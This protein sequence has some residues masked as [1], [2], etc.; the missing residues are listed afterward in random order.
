M[1]ARAQVPSRDDAQAFAG[2]LDEKFL[3]LLE[4]APA[5]E[6]IVVTKRDGRIIRV[7]TQTERL[8]DYPRKELLGQNVEVL[9]QRR[10]QHRHV[11]KQAAYFSH[12]RVRLM[13]TGLEL[14]AR[15]KDGTEFPIDVSFTPLETGGETLVFGFIRDITE[16]KRSEEVVSHLAAI[17]ETSDDAIIG[18]SLDGTILSW[19]LG[20]ERLYGYKAEE[21]VGRPVALLV[22]PD[23]PDELGWIMK[24][25]RRGKHIEHYETTR[26]RKDGHR[27]DISVT[28]SPVKNKAGSV[29][30]ASVIARDI[31]DRKRIEMALRQSEER[32]RVAL[33]NAPVRV[34]NQDLDLRF[35]WI[36]SHIMAWAKQDCLGKTDAEIVDG[37]EGARLMAF[38]KEVLRT[39]RGA[40]TESEVTVDGEKFYFNVV[41]EP[42]RDVNGTIVGLTCSATDI[43]PTKKSLLE[44]E[45]LIAKLQDALE[46]VKLLSG[47]LS[48]CASCKKITNER[49]DWEPMESYLQT[50][51]QAKFSHG[52]CPDCLRKLYPEQYREWEQEV[53]AGTSTGN[54]SDIREA[55]LRDDRTKK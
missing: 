55:R 2:S 52:L 51:S 14:C 27:I 42:L 3:Q 34:F 53:V 38:K 1:A 12:P 24:G 33:K 22:P 10:V 48:I 9:L 4:S 35:T 23:R 37:E 40:R 7:N 6:A 39:G 46:E 31:T 8:F 29:V 32:F 19:N 49:G 45:V 28:V 47:L 18:K 20:A 30:G 16:R 17:V 36:N 11:K 43:T 5:P 50:H 15:R 21:V 41:A 44:R 25:L 13:G 26:V 54:A